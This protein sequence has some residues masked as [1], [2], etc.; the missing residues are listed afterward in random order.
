MTDILTFTGSKILTIEEPEILFG[1]PILIEERFKSLAKKWHPDSPTGDTEIFQHINKLHVKAKELAAKGSWHI[2]GEFTFKSGGSE[3]VLRYFKS[4][5]F[6]LGKAYMSES[7]LTYVFAKEFTDLAE[8]A[9]KMIESLKFQDKKT[10]EVMRLYL[11]NIVGYYETDN[12]AILMIDKPKDLVRMR[13]VL[14][15]YKGKVDP[16]HVA[17]MVSRM[18][19]HASY[20]QWMNISHGDLSIDSLYICPELHTVCVLGG[21]WYATPI[22][23]KPKALPSRTISN[24]PS[25]FLKNKLST[26]GTDPELVRLTAR[27]MLG[28][29]N[30]I[31]LV[32]DT[33]IPKSMTNWL[34][35]SGKGD[36]SDDYAQW[37]EK[38]V[39]S[40]FG[41]REFHIMPIT[42]K[43]VYTF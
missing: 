31:H 37:L 4:Y 8:N 24:L 16:R 23:E 35:V 39:I 14:D 33:N 26:F 13:D 20:F 6:D 32:S 1:K 22:G 15:F 30:G 29:A 41:K 25:E 18:I 19:H 28:N 12:G 36:A 42:S 3:Y 27:E 11:P 43:D 21:W 7:R 9:K 40:S 34:R 10:E 17:W 5:D 2:P 38:I